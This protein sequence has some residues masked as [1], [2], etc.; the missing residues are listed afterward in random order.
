M[1]RRITAVAAAAGLLMTVGGS[2]GLATE[3]TT[4]IIK[5]ATETFNDDLGCL[6]PASITI[7]YRGVFH[8]TENKRGDHYTGTLTGKFTA[9]PEG[10]GLPDYAGRF[11]TRF[12]GNFR[13]DGRTE[14]FMLSITGRA[15]DGSGRM[16]FHQLVHVTKNR[17]GTSVEFEKTKC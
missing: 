3:T 5:R 16:R 7:T 4:E 11:T 17:N 10:A 15:T 8:E 6:G 9:D 12:G 2:P 13:E 1:R 14:T